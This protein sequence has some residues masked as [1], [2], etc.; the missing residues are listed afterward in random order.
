[1]LTTHQQKLE[2]ATEEIR[3]W[4][5]RHESGGLSKK[6]L[7]GLVL[8]F[9]IRTYRQNGH[10]LKAYLREMERAWNVSPP[11]ADDEPGLKIVS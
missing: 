9:V 2:T 1:M 4:Y 7:L 6:D 8:G 10:D 5:S 11:T 3:R